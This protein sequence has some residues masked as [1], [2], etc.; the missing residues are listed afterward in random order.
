MSQLTHYIK[1]LN[2]PGGHL[3]GSWAVSGACWDTK[4]V[5]E[6]PTGGHDL[7]PFQKHLLLREPAAVWQQKPFPISSGWSVGHSSLWVLMFHLYSNG[8]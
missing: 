3:E 4:V 5:K 1:S 2:S 7:R 6:P 8:L